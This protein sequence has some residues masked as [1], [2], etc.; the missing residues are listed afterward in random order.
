MKDFNCDGHYIA[1][2]SA[3]AA[4]AECI[5]LY[6]HDPEVIRPWNAEDENDN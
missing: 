2:E 6:G 1:A 3:D 4:R 5:A